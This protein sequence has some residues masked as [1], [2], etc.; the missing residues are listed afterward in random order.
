MARSRIRWLAV[1]AAVLVVTQAQVGWAENPQKASKKPAK[2]SRKSPSTNTEPKT[3]HAYRLDNLGNDPNLCQWVADTIPEVIQRDMGSTGTFK[4]YAPARILV[5][6]H[7][8]AVQA[9]VEAFLENLKDALPQPKEHPPTS[10]AKTQLMLPAKFSGSVAKTVVTASD[11][12][13][14]TQPPRH[15][16]HII[17]EGLEAKGDRVNLKNFTIRYEGEG[18]IDSNLAW[19]IKSLNEQATDKGEET[20]KISIT[21]E[22]LTRCLQG[23]LGII[24]SG[25]F[26]T[27]SPEMVPIESQ[28]DPAPETLPPVGSTVPVP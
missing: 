8:P 18:I 1:L 22:D 28:P 2:S 11:S 24:G 14:A 7:T 20:R 6:Y 10:F 23:I 3:W 27:T 17:L 26:T 12:G 16:F 15:L 5:V 25:G 4:Y 13:A 9:Q 19:L 21:A